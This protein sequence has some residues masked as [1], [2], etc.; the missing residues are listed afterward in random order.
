MI[1]KKCYTCQED[2]NNEIYMLNDR[3][4]CEPCWSDQYID[5]KNTLCPECK[6]YMKYEYDLMCESCW[7]NRDDKYAH[8]RG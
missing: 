5:G 3:L 2:I 8:Y 6:K 1:E 7:D 4:A